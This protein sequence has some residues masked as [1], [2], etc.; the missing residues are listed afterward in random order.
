M[1][2]RCGW[3]V[4]RF[5]FIPVLLQHNYYYYYQDLL[6]ARLYGRPCGCRPRNRIYSPKTPPTGIKLICMAIR[7]RWYIII[8][9]LRYYIMMYIH[10]IRY[11]Q[12]LKRNIDED[13][14]SSN[15]RTCVLTKN[16]HIH[17]FI[18]KKMQPLITS[19]LIFS[20]VKNH[21]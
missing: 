21:L 9:L 5:D 3:V 20:C 6:Y 10:S 17:L 18:L 1:S 4:S 11:R 19:Q 15:F 16:L 2:L 7:A 14:S 13:P 12:N 8:L